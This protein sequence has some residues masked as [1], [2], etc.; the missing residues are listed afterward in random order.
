M[1]VSVETITI[2]LAFAF[3]HLLAE[4]FIIRMESQAA[5]TS[6]M[7]YTITCL[8]GRFGWIP[9][10]EKFEQFA[11]DENVKSFKDDY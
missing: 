10:S 5:N 2:S 11:T 9:F 7:H 6:M 3:A 1:G 4:L 8:I